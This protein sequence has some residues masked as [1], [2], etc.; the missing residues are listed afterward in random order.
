MT[1]QLEHLLVEAANRAG[2][3]VVERRSTSSILM[4]SAVWS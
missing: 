3:T 4:G 2:A 1:R